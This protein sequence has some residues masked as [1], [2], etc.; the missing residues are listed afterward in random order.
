[1][2]NDNSSS[3]LFIFRIKSALVVLSSLYCVTHTAHIVWKNHVKISSDLH[4]DLERI[5][6]ELLSSLNLVVD[7]AKF[8]QLHNLARG[9][10]EVGSEYQNIELEEYDYQID[11]GYGNR[12]F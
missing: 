6:S 7:E 5:P 11:Y 1:M 8:E 9:Q 12:L 4:S 10:P 2:I 3:S